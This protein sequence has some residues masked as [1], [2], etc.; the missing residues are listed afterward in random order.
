MVD[1]GR[2]PPLGPAA[3]FMVLFYDKLH[4]R[5]FRGH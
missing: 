3:I 5:G 1:A 4:T 2:L